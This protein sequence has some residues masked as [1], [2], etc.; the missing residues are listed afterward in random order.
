VLIDFE[1]T[2]QF[3]CVPSEMALCA[4][5]PHHGIVES[6]H[7]FI[8]PALPITREQLRN[9]NF[10]ESRVTGIPAQ[11]GPG[12]RSDYLQLVL[13]VESFLRRVQAVGLYAKDARMENK[14][15]EWLVR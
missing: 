9:A 13:D 4:F 6:W 12:A 11:G 14:C 3:G 10:T 5:S 7:C 8:K 1:V 2:I 15:V